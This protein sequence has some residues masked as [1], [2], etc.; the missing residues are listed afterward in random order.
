MVLVQG[1]DHRAFSFL[2]ERYAHNL[3][4]F[5]FRMLWSDKNL[6]EDHVQ[7]L[8]SRIIEKP[9]LYRKEYLVKPW[10]YKIASNMCKNAY[11]KRCFELEY[12]KQLDPHGIQMNDVEQ[13]IDE[14]IMTD[15]LY[16]E[17]EKLDEDKRT[18]FLLRY[19]QELS[20]LE[21]AEILEEAEGTIKSRL[22]YI[23]KKL[24]EKLDN[25]IKPIRHGKKSI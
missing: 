14:K 19:Q 15:Q 18:L 23:K 10:L 20:I 25:H 24:T 13:K 4:A 11:R 16:L 6:A 9:H 7:E 3:N 17:L 5:F 22:F 12:Q 1:G 8:F 21:I 2:Y